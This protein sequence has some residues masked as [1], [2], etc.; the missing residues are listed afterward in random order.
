MFSH[1]DGRSGLYGYKADGTGQTRNDGIVANTGLVKDI[2][3][4]NILAGTVAEKY[5]Q[6]MPLGNV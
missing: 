5:N 2:L 1:S 6:N 4:N 3:G